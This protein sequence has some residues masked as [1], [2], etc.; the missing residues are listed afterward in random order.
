MS[1]SDIRTRRVPFNS[2]IQIRPLDYR[3]ITTDAE[4]QKFCEDIS[5][6][7]FI[8]FDTEF[9]SEDRF[10]PELCLLQVAAA[11]EF[12]VIDPFPISDLN[13]FWDLIVAGATCTHN[14]ISVFDFLYESVT[15]HFQSVAGPSLVALDDSS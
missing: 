3:H 14:G 2:L 4:L 13:C 11:G 5:N 6:A 8:A 9:V 7:E 12:A 10:L 1:A 15:A